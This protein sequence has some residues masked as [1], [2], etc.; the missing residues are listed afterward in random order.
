MHSSVLNI[1]I[2][3]SHTHIYA[4]LSYMLYSDSA[5]VAFQLNEV[6]DG[7]SNMLIKCDGLS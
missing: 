3:I 1:C 7:R 6:W 2:Y 5:F 4:H